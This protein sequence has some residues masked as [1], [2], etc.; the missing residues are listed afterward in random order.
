MTIKKLNWEDYDGHFGKSW[1][2]ETG[3][4]DNRYCISIDR[5]T[6]K[7]IGIGLDRVKVEFN[8]IQEAKD[9]FQKDFESK[10]KMLF[11]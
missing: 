3:D 11:Q 4:F 2:A 9:I 5:Q 6:G 8:N 1:M 10:V 7:T